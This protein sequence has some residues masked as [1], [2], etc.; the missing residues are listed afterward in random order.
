M[1]QP[2]ENPNQAKVLFTEL[3][4]ALKRAIIVIEKIY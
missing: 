1:E 4:N 2:V 3:F